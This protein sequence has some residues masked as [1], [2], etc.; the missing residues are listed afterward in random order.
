MHPVVDHAG[1]WAGSNQFRLMPTDPF[2]EAPATAQV[3]VA[4]GGNLASIAYSWSH[5]QDGA[6]DGLLVVGGD[7]SGGVVALW[8]DSWHQSPEA[9]VLLGAI[10]D[11]LIVAGCDYGGDWRWTITVDTTVDG[12]LRIRM[13]NVIPESAATEEIGPGAYAAMVAELRRVA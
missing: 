4:A 2:Q 7:D 12:S 13:D 3:S 6:Q 1:A 5:P 8:G 9:R 11:G 10:K